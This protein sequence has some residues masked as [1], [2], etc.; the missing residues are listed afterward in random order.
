[1]AA[2]IPE[3]K[4]HICDECALAEWDMKFPNLDMWGKPTLLRCPH[5]KFAIIRGTQ[6]CG[7]FKLK[8][9]K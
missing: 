5:H 1:M 9:S 8:E 7:N 2:P 4:K 6:A 3:H